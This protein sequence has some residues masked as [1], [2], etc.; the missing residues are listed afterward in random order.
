MAEQFNLTV[1]AG[2]TTEIEF[3]HK[4]DPATP[5]DL[6]AWT[7]RM[8]VRPA[9]NAPSTLMSFDSD[10]NGLVIDGPQGKVTLTISPSDTNGI[11]AP[12]AGRVLYYDLEILNGVGVVYR[13]F[14]GELLL[15][16]QITITE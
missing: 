4:T 12:A 13:T 6:T 3:I 2:S 15:R 1:N 5:K 16:P 9:Y 7:A 14:E 11:P 8:Q 10:G